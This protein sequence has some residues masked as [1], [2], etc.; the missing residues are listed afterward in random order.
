MDLCGVRKTVD[1]EEDDERSVVIIRDRT[2]G[3]KGSYSY[4]SLAVVL[5]NP[6][7]DQGFDMSCVELGATPA[8]SQGRR[9]AA[10]GR[11]VT[12]TNFPNTDWS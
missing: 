4:R 1:M 10:G 8:R 5:S 6:M 7:V 12:R 11:A 2:I 3:D 9:A